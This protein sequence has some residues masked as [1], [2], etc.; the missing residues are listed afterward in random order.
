MTTLFHAAPGT[1]GYGP[2]IERLPSVAALAEAVA[3]RVET[4]VSQGV[5]RQG[6]ASLIFSGGGT[7]ELF[8]P[9]VAGA[10]VPWNKVNILL[11]DERWVDGNSAYSNTAMLRRTLL[12]H[13]GPA[14]AK[15]VPLKN[16]AAS[17]TEGVETARSGLPPLDQHSNHLGAIVRPKGC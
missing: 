17:A 10:D 11:A 9:R 2:W 7:P 15:F 1:T 16:A 3:E 6:R 4:A 5:R 8:L 12:T 14:Q 13:A